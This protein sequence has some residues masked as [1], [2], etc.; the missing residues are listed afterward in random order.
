MLVR[1]KCNFF[2]NFYQNM[3][4]FA[5]F[6]SVQTQP[7]Y[8]T[9]STQP[10]PFKKV[11]YQSSKSSNA[12]NDYITVPTT[13]RQIPVELQD[14]LVNKTSNE[15]NLED[16]MAELVACMKVH[17]HKEGNICAV[18]KHSVKKRFQNFCEMFYDNCKA[19]EARWHYTEDS[20]C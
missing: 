5:C 12:V 6:V 14:F 2:L 8:S 16:C 4:V 10:G 13:A 17:V 15:M 7:E 11:V 1:T 20:Q 3:I 9:R 18:N 19:Y